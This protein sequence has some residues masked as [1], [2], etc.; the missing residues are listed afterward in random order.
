[1]KQLLP[2]LMGSSLLLSQLTHV[3]LYQAYFVFRELVFVRG[4]LVFSFSDDGDALLHAEFLH[5]IG[6]QIGD[7]PCPMKVLLEPFAAWQRIQFSSNIFC[8]GFTTLPV[9]AC[10]CEA[11]AAGFADSCWAISRVPRPK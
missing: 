2:D 6:A 3:A 7:V 9:S 1:M 5:N 10:D 11:G 8:P 4:H